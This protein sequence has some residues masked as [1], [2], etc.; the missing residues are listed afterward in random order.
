MAS[1]GAGFDATLRES[2]VADRVVGGYHNG[3]WQ[4]R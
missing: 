4:G 2:T 3:V 1:Q